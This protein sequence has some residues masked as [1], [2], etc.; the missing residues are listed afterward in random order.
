MKSYKTLIEAADRLL[1]QSKK[2]CEEL[3]KQL[4]EAQENYEKHLNELEAQLPKHGEWI[5]EKD[6]YGFFDTIPVCSICGQTTKM[7][8]KTRFC[9]WCG[10]KM[11]V[12]E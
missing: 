12:Q 5:N 4:R 8:D 7:R 3:R 2:R 9:P 6:P 11:G 1:D 10:A